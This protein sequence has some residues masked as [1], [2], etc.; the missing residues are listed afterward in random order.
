VEKRKRFKVK[1]RFYAG[2]RL[3]VLS[4]FSLWEKAR[5]RGDIETSL[6]VIIFPLALTLLPHPNPL[7]KG[8]GT[9][10]EKSFP[11]SLE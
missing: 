10:S 8:E 6:L 3:F 5:M 11:V 2:E 9:K 1:A 4:S 7:P